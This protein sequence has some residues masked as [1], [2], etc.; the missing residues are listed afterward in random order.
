MITIANLLS[1]HSCIA[2]P[3]TF[4]FQDNNFGY[5]VI[6]LLIEKLSELDF[7]IHLK[8]RIFDPLGLE[9]TTTD[10]VSIDANTGRYY[11]VLENHSRCRVPGPKVGTGSLLDGA[12]GVKSTIND[13]LHLYRAFLEAVN[14]QIQQGSTSTKGSPFKQCSTLIKG[15]SFF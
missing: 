11:C 12:A 14:D 7:G 4:F 2:S 8:N 6:A 9:R 10:N 13:L 3:D 1:H 15:H 5:A